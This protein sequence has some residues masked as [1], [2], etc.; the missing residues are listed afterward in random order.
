MHEDF[1]VK[2]EE[3]ELSSKDEFKEIVLKSLSSLD[4]KR[5]DVVS[6]ICQ[7]VT[8][9][10]KKNHLLFNNNIF[11]DDDILFDNNF[12]FHNNLFFDNNILRFWKTES[13]IY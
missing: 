2:Y 3:T 7:L 9:W 12:L 11:F 4:V 6:R 13:K 8:D 1:S 5:W 10:V